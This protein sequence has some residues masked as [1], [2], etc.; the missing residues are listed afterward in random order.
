LTG[1]RKAHRERK[2]ASFDNDV[3]LPGYVTLGAM[4]YY[5]AKRFRVQINLK[6]LTNKKYY[7][8][9]SDDNQIMPGAPSGGLASLSMKF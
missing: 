4:A 2:Y 9:A 6:N 1:A 3:I 7:P 8:T 5:Q